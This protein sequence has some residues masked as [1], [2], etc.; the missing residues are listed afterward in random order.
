MQMVKRI[1]MAAVLLLWVI[2]AFAQPSDSLGTIKIFT[3]RALAT[4]LNEVGKEF[5]KN[6][7]YQLDITTDIAIR[8]VRKIQGGEPFDVLVASP[9][10][11]DSLIKEGKIIT[12]SKTILARSGIGVAVRAGTKKPDISTVEAFKTALLNAGSV[13]YLKEGQSGIYLAALFERLGLTKALQH[14]VVR[15]EQDIVSMLVAEGKVEIGLVVITQIQT[16]PGV[17]LVGPLP[18]EVQSYVVF[19]GGVSTNSKA[20]DVAIQLMKFLASPRA[21]TV[22]KIQGM[23]PGGEIEH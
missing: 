3:T 23:Q 18:T 5:E 19:A 8:M 16:T 21:M 13:A 14:K 15:P 2:S 1:S 11:I 12:Q 6:T 4:V 22:M 20:P 10:Q 17:E 9:D 7:G